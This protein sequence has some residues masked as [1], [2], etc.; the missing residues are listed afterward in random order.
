MLLIGLCASGYQV[1]ES[2]LDLRARG[3]VAINPVISFVPPER[4]EGAPVDPR[5]RIALPQDDVAPAFRKGGR[6][7]RLRER[8]PNLAWRTRILLSPRRRSG[9]WLARLVKQGT[10]TLIICGDS[11]IRPLQQG[12]STAGLRRLRRSGLL[13]LEHVAELDHALTIAAHRQ[14]V[15]DMVTDHVSRSLPSATTWISPCRQRPT[16][17]TE[18]RICLVCGP[19]RTI[20]ILNDVIDV[21][22]PDGQAD[23][24]W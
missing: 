8:Y 6:F 5:R 12:S 18:R 24:V 19:E 16:G 4:R 13:R 3:V 20:E 1:L 9:K 7:E 17:G 11:E 23:H 15:H 2:G 22:D 14:S 21:F 10:D